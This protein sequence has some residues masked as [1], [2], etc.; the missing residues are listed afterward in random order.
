M[1]VPAQPV[2]KIV[3]LALPQ[4]QIAPQEQIVDPDIAIVPLLEL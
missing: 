2:L 1:L 4:V 3:R